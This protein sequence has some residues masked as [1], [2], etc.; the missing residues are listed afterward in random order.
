MQTHY[1]HISGGTSV[2]TVFVVLVGF[3]G[4]NSRN[5]LAPFQVAVF[6]IKISEWVYYLWNYEIT[7]ELTQGDLWLRMKLNLSSL[8]QGRLSKHSTRHPQKP[9]TPHSV[10]HRYVLVVFNTVDTEEKYLKL[11]YCFSL[12]S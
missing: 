5:L 11:Q 4:W 2:L 1:R 8:S 7:Q 9:H 3:L 6:V 10:H 12:W